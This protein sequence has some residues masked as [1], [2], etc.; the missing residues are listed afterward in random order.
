MNPVQLLVDGYDDT[1]RMLEE[2][3]KT[4]AAIKYF[5]QANYFYGQGQDKQAERMMD[6]FNKVANS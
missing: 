2:L 4:K 1:T 5:E 3:K 6:K